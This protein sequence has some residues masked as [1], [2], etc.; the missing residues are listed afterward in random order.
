[1][2]KEERVYKKGWREER[3]EENAL[4]KVQFWLGV[5]GAHL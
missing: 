4:I 5:S 3:E 2:E 1:M